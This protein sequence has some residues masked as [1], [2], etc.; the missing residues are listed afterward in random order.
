VKA[1][2]LYKGEICVQS[3]QK[4]GIAKSYP[5]SL[6]KNREQ[7][8]EHT[9]NCLRFSHNPFLQVMLPGFV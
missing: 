1:F 3:E 7:S 5:Y 4:E 9:G 6:A 2:T 8:P